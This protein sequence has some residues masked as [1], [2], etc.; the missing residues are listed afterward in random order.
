MLID[1]LKAG[2]PQTFHLFKK[3]EKKMQYLQSAVK[4]S[5]IKQGMPI[6]GKLLGPYVSKI[7]PR[8][9]DSCDKNDKH[10]HSDS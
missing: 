3:K 9:G 10:S 2:L 1:L 7:E 5:T 8:S 4:Q 6:H